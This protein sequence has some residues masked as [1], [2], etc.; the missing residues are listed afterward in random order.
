MSIL[1]WM[2]HKD[3]LRTFGFTKAEKPDVMIDIKV[4]SEKK[5]TATATNM[6]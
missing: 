6:P 2:T 4:T 5:E 3:S 1:I